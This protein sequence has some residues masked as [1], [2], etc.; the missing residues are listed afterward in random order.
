MIG[1]GTADVPRPG[2]A[3]GFFVESIRVHS[4]YIL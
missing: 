1:D 2:S 4:R 3:E